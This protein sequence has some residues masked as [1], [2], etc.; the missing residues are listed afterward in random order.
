MTNVPPQPNRYQPA[1]QE[2]LKKFLR[3][4]HIGG[5]FLHC[6]LA[7]HMRRAGSEVN[8]IEKKPYHGQVWVLSCAEEWCLRARKASGPRVASVCF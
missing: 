2:T 8:A 4:R 7:L 3:S 5:L 6:Q 1:W